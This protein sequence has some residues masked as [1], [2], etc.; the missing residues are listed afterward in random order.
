MN[1]FERTPGNIYSVINTTSSNLLYVSEHFFSK[2]ENFLMLAKSEAIYDVYV[3]RS[4]KALPAGS[5]SLK[6]VIT[7]NNVLC[8]KLFSATKHPSGKKDRGAIW[9]R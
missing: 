1:E 8:W 6:F 9:N 7:G 5:A 2:N 4:R 3:S